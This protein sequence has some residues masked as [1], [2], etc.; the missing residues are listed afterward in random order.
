MLASL[1]YFLS[2]VFEKDF[3]I[4]FSEVLRTV[5]YRNRS[6]N[7]RKLHLI[8]NRFFLCISALNHKTWRLRKY[9]IKDAVFLNGPGPLYKI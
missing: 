6:S 4:F 3:F 5:F 8:D 1:I 2:V 9:I 7:V